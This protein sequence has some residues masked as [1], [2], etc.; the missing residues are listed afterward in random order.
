MISS[1]YNRCQTVVAKNIRKHNELNEFARQRDLHALELLLIFVF[2]C[3]GC[4][5][6]TQMQEPKASA[7]VKP[8]SERVCNSPL[9]PICILAL[10]HADGS[11]CVAS[12]VITYG[13]G[14]CGFA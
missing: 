12:S 10:A 11:A 4:L 1:H 13:I 8:L 6:P 14:G 5:T 3:F 2:V 7:L 9:E